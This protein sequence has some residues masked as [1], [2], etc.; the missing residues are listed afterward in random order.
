MV[1]KLK[2][3]NKEAWDVVKSQL[4]QLQHKPVEVGIITPKPVY[5]PDTELMED[6]EPLEGFHVDIKLGNVTEEIIS[7]ALDLI[8]E[9]EIEVDNPVHRFG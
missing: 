5:N 4:P 1:K 3:T 9:Y 6:Q 8:S 2:F 7:E